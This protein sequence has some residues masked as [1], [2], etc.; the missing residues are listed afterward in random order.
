MNPVRVGLIGLGTV[1]CGVAKILLE[2]R[3]LIGRK[4]GRPLVLAKIADLDLE[5]P[6][7]VSVDRGLL[8]RDAFE[9]INDPEI[10]IIVELIGGYEPAKTF[11]LQAIEA[12]KHIVTA[13]KALLAVHGQEIFAAAA[14]AGVDILF[15]ASVAGGIPIIRTLKEGLPA[16]HINYFFGILNGTSN[17]ILT[18]MTQE[19][20]NFAQA[21][22]E[23]QD[24]GFAETDPTFDIEGV[25]TAHKLVILTALAYGLN[26]DLKDI[27]VEGIS[28][29]DPLDIKFADEFGYVIKLLAISARAGDKIE[30]RIHP[31]M[32]PKGHLLSAVNGPFNAIHI[33][34]HAVGDILLYGAG[35]GMMPTASAVAGDVIEL[36]RGI[37]AQAQARVP[38]LAWRAMDDQALSLRPMEEV[39]ATYYFRFSVL[40]R[41]GVLSKISGVLGAHDI[42]ISAVSQKGREKAGAVPIVMLTHEAKEAAVRQALSE[43]DH[44]DVVKDKTVVIRV[45][46]RLQ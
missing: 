12:G 26:V 27:H 11:I 39:T 40:D 43:I 6:R 5:T 7:P 37:Q 13:N 2:E 14:L 21:L 10:E 46:D 30:A 3:D 22:C 20:M 42:S 38:A 16:N 28:N 25:D 44:L 8:T 31:A 1:G 29:L 33:N 4:L 35:A 32:L 19:G 23:A 34:G 15:E 36:A 45:E 9:I 24:K 17:Y 18:K 41:P